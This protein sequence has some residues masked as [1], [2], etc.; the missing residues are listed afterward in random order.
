MWICHYV[1]AAIWAWVNGIQDGLII[2]WI[3]NNRRDN[4]ICLVILCS[5]SSTL[6]SWCVHDD[7]T[8]SSSSSSWTASRHSVTAAYKLTTT[9]ELQATLRS[10]A[11]DAIKL[12]VRWSRLFAG[13]QRVGAA[14]CG[15]GEWSDQCYLVVQSVTDG[16]L[17]TTLQPR[18]IQ[19]TVFLLQTVQRRR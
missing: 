11:S 6:Q 19:S 3:M 16:P 5:Q 13:D 12:L 18:T 1:S 7:E 4:T 15:T 17:H 8:S 14:V 2:C 9:G 10:R